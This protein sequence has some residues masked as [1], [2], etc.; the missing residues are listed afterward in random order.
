M[1]NKELQLH[2]EA[3]A[4]EAEV[5]ASKG[6]FKEI[7]NISLQLSNMHRP[8]KRPKLDKEEHTGRRP[9]E[10]VGPA[11]WGTSES[12]D[13]EYCTWHSHSWGGPRGGLWNPDKRGNEI[14]SW[15]TEKLQSC[16]PWWDSSENHESGRIG[17]NR[18]FTCSV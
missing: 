12:G 3:L 6:N 14:S 15:T 16:W 7:Y 9:I 10:K 17:F 18:H 5:T 11:F 1:K 8:A 13:S 2:F 4:T